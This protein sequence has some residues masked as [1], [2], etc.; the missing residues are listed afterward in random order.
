MIVM[1]ALTL[2]KN[3]ER[4]FDTMYAIIFSYVSTK[5]SI[6]ER[7]IEEEEEKGFLYHSRNRPP[8]CDNGGL[9]KEKKAPITIWSSDEGDM[10][11]TEETPIVVERK[12]EMNLTWETIE[13][14]QNKMRTRSCCQQTDGHSNEEPYSI[15]SEA[16]Q[17]EELV[18]HRIG[19]K[20]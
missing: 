6:V 13:V 10:A 15:G 12:R 14:T 5:E 11:R 8:P 7:L 17:C 2:I 3:P 9:C 19:P 4:A 18:E 16:W 20:R 1:N